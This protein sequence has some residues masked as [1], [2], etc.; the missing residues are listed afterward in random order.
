M[1]GTLLS[2][3]LLNKRV[4]LDIDDLSVR[5]PYGRLVCVVYLTGLYGQPILT[6][7]F[8][9]MLVDS[10]Y[11][12]I[13]NSTNSEFDP[14]KWWPDNSAGNILLPEPSEA[15]GQLKRFED[16]L[17]QSPDNAND[18]GKLVNQAGDWLRNR[19]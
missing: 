14:S 6:P 18:I 5:D 13:E 7:C 15:I 17:N 4:Y 19:I 9:R 11:A 1:Q 8:N 2:A 16:I 3:V 12:K 10:G